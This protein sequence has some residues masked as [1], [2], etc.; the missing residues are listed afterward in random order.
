MP[1]TRARVRAP[2][3]DD[4]LSVAA[5]CANRSLVA[6]TFTRRVA[7]QQEHLA[8]AV[9]GRARNNSVGRRA[10][11]QFLND[12]GDWSLRRRGVNVF[13]L[14]AVDQRA[15]VVVGVK[16]LVASSSSSSSAVVDWCC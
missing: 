10:L 13:F 5:L 6:V 7:R 4:A 12:F 8:F 14:R 15:L 16:V 11:G 2:P 1:C 9:G 3:I